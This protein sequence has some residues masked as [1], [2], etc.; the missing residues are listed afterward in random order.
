MT[1]TLWGLE[2]TLKHFI[3][4][5]RS[6]LRTATDLSGMR[7]H[8][9]HHPHRIVLACPN[10]NGIKSNFRQRSFAGYSR[11]RGI[12]PE[13]SVCN[14]WKIQ[15]REITCHLLSSLLRA[16]TK[17]PE[18]SHRQSKYDCG[19][20]VSSPKMNSSQHR[21]SPSSLDQPKPK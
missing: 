20:L 21:S 11:P 7:V 10:C 18:A 16:R 1:R 12:L 13:S 17:S 2:C 4:R 19:I 3:P 8:T 9:A 6:P 5:S 15:L 14:R